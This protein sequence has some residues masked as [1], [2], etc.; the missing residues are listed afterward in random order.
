V[1]PRIAR[2]PWLVPAL[3]AA[4][5]A[6]VPLAA[7]APASRPVE[8][9]YF[10]GAGCPHCAAMSA[11]LGR[12]QAEQPR[13]RVQAYEVYANRDNARLLGR[14]AAGYGTEIEG[15]PMVFVGDAAFGGYSDE[16][17]VRIAQA[18][19]ACAARD[20][21]SPLARAA[22]S[23]PPAALTLSAVLAAAAV[24]AI[25][26]C[27]FAVL[28][29]LLTA[30]LAAGTRRRALLAGLAF[31]AS[32]FI[33][34]YLMGLGLYSAARAAGVTR[35]IYA[36]VAALA[37]LIG[38]FNLKDFLWYGKWFRMEVPLAWRPAM[39]RILGGVTSVPGAFV[40]GFVVSLF[41]LPCTSGPY[42]VILG[43]L[44]RSAARSEAMLWLLL[45]NAIFV[46]PMLAITGAVTLG[47]TTLD[48]VE[49]WRTGHIR[50]LHLAAGI[51]LLALGAGMLVAL[52]SGWL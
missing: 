17:A 48:D 6:L 34:Y 18:I 16:I 7:R 24:D 20:C 40:I 36:A 33:S 1:T 50:R 2:R 11:F 45:Y 52:W 39:Q 27:A 43:L 12:M 30:I 13:L 9:A 22:R 28:I 3:L 38:L 51:V 19:R 26:P 21:G 37:I 49:V 15:V 35:A 8:L 10:Y 23:A 32:I 4:A 41:L 14:V 46:L 25:N 42:V 44:A 29:I 47:L 5:L 31:S